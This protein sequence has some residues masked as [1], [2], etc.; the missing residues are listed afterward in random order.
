MTRWRNIETVPESTLK[1]IGFCKDE[2]GYFRVREFWRN[3]GGN[4]YDLGE[5]TD[6]K[7]MKPVFWIP[8][9]ELPE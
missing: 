5:V 8:F 3:P 6:A 4:W 1:I 7:E 9:P 2:T